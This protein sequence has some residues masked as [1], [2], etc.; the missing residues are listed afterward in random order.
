VVN[1]LPEVAGAIGDEPEAVQ[2]GHLTAGVV[3]TPMHGEGGLTVIASDVDVRAECQPT[4][5]YF[6]RSVVSHPDRSA[7]LTHWE[8]S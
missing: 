4:T 6:T 2:G 7:R 3:V 1:G 5:E 8:V